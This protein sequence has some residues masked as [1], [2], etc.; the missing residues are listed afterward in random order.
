MLQSHTDF[1]SLKTC[2]VGR[3]YPPEF[4]SFIENPRLRTLFEQIATET[5]EDFQFLIKKLKEFNVN[6]L[7][8][9]EIRYVP[10]QL[11]KKGIALPSPY[12]MVP[13]DQLAM[14]GNNLYEFGYDCVLTRAGLSDQLKTNWTEEYYHIVK[15]ENWPEE[16]ID[17]DLL[18][19][20]IKKELENSFD[21]EHKPG[22]IDDVIRKFV[23]FDCWKP[24]IDFVKSSGNSVVTS[25]ELPLLRKMVP[26]GIVRLGKDLLIGIDSYHQLEEDLVKL[27]HEQ[28]EDYRCRFVESDGHVDGCLGVIKPGLLLTINEME[29]YDYKK[30]FPDW[31]IVS[32]PGQSWQGID[33]WIDLKKKNLGKWWIQGYER[34][35]ELI[36]LVEDW[37]GNWMGYVEETVFD[38]NVLSVDEKNVFVTNY[39]KSV[40]DAFERHGV[41][42]H[43]IPWRHRY[44]WDGGLHCITCDLDREGERLSYL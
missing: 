21:F 14:I 37:F 17:Y 7:R 18:S 20:E 35:D 25:D 42:P 10:S 5:E 15:G 41:T 3:S 29:D 24:V 38:V 27:Q 28:F 31:E 9:N 13:R 1:Q 23:E 8:P 40:F 11:K 19:A 30:N 39:N 4:Y 34:D 33:G 26:N 6:V 32:L 36:N 12:S 43:I 2:V 16:F 44:F 22:M